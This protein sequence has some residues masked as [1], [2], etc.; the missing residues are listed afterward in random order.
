MVRRLRPA[1]LLAVGVV[2]AAGQLPA[3]RRPMAPL[4]AAALRKAPKPYDEPAKAWEF[5]A[6]KRA[7]VGQTAIP[8]ERYVAAR[9]RMS[10]MRRYSTRMGRYL[11]RPR[12]GLTAAAGA[13]GTWSALGPGNIGGRTRALLIDPGT[14]TTMYAAGVAGGV[15]KTTNGGGTWAPLDDFMANLAVNAMAMDPASPSTLYAGTGEGFFNIDAVRGA[16]IFKT[17]NG[18]TTWAALPNTVNANFHY[19][20][21]VIVSSN[22]SQRVYAATRTG[23]WRSTNG[24][25]NW[26]LIMT[27]PRSARMLRP[28][29][30]PRGTRGRDLRLLREHQ[31]QR[32]RWRH[33]APVCERRY[34]GH[35]C[36]RAQRGPDGP[37]LA[38]HRPFGPERPL[39]PLR[40]RRQRLGQLLPGSARGLSLHR[41][42]ADLDRRRCDNTSP[43][44]LN[45]LL[46]TNPVF[47]RLTECGFGSSSF[48]N[49]GWYDN[50]I[51]VDPADANSVWAGGIDLFRS[52][53]GGANWGLASYWWAP[54]TNPH[55]AHAD[56]H[57]I[58]F[59]PG[60]NGTAN[61][62]MFVG[63]DG[64]VFRTDNAARPRWPPGPLA[65]CNPANAASPG[66]SATTT[67]GSRSST[68]AFP[69]PA[70]R[71]TSGAPRTTAP[72][73][74]PTGAV[75]RL[76]RDLRR[77]RRRGGGG[78]DATP[79]SSTPRHSI[80]RS[81][82][83]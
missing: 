71:P 32:L 57:A 83:P 60:Y 6:K 8:T 20:N 21:D 49:Q 9:K 23:V 54:T 7:P 74:A 61:Q 72:C 18:G 76:G 78:P 50:V 4:L 70:V 48:S 33:R 5:Y 25:V 12:A 15:W 66:R 55:Y 27:T 82:N 37:N 62:M 81:R 2:A 28:P 73:A 29:P 80:C 31:F 1:A 67:T 24:G 65:A 59:H 56:Q 39:R 35:L 36:D 53:D 16:G 51:A 75:R 26:T 44:K 30:T 58:A 64:G 40:Q 42:R 46:L 11:P 19:V 14:P 43:T 77:R 52:D 47:A 22:D 38:G 45:T 69:I 10:T 34:P 79:T 68:T 3:P 41:R 17:T 63:N 13:L